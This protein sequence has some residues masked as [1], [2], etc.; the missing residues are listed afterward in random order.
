MLEDCI[1][2]IPD[3]DTNQAYM[4]RMALIIGGTPMGSLSQ[5]TCYSRSRLLRDLRIKD[6]YQS[7]FIRESSTLTSVLTLK[8]LHG[9]NLVRAT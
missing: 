7:A 9:L 6:L 3:Y 4:N 5:R 8:T 2:L 1:D